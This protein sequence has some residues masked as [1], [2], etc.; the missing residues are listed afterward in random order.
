MS[1][2]HMRLNSKDE[3]K[4]KILKDKYGYTQTSELVRYLLNSK[5]EEEMKKEGQVV[6]LTTPKRK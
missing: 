4:I 3:D 1:T 5:L 2:F 6:S